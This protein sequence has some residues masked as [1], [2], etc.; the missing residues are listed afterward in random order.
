MTSEL[1]YSGCDALVQA[2]KDEGVDL[3]FGYPG[4]AVIPEFDALYREHFPVALV[5]HEQGAT[6]AAE[7]YAKSTGKTG[8]VM[9]TSGPGATNA[10]TGVA[11]AMRDSVPMVVF[12]GQV[13]TK[14]LGKEAFQEADAMA[15]MKPVT[16]QTFQVRQ[17]TEVATVVHQAFALAKSG[18]PGPVLVDLPKDV[19]TGRIATLPSHQ[20]SPATA[21]TQV[22]VARVKE[23]AAEL[24][25]AK[26]PLVVVGG[27]AVI[28]EAAH[29][30]N[31]LVHKYQLPVV[32][33][34]LGL[35]VV[36]NNDSLCFGMAG[37][38]GSFVANT[39][40]EKCDFVLGIGSR[41]EDR[42]ATDAARF[43][44]QAKV[45]Q[46]DVNPHEPGRN[47]QVDFALVGDAKAVVTQLLQ[48]LTTVA[49]HSAWNEQL[50]A[51]Q[52]ARPL[53]YQQEPDY[54][55]PEQVVQAVGKATNGRAYVVTDVGQ[56]QMWAA[57]FYPFTF[58]R[59]LITS[60][61]F[62]TMGFGLPAAVGTQFAHRDEPVVL[63]TGD[64]SLQMTVQELDVVTQ[65]R[66]NLKIVL[67]NNRRLGM[68]RQWQDLFFE[69]R[70]AS[71]ILEHQ[72][73]FQQLTQAYGLSNHRLEASDDW[74]DQLADFLA[75][76]GPG[77]LEVATAPDHQA[78]PMIFPGKSNGELYD[79]NY[80]TKEN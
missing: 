68:V 20:G 22:P 61:G 80:P 6:H 34:L 79:E 74:Q 57:Q 5:R 18:R 35:G 43:A 8:V 54:L 17:T 65:Y 31:T 12:S 71:T 41:F 64:G 14:F 25:H 38:H 39:A 36:P 42:F 70:R 47:V 37:M 58:P 75:T 53:T 63:F 77:L 29:E 51:W 26:R 56:H 19:M 52:N 21:P 7:G 33:T 27:G 73:N 4:G 28:A 69:H 49:E 40:L 32:T 15:L 59:Q 3:L 60:G 16:K 11:D 23:V 55:A 30:V 1:P 67:F 66:L 50:A 24:A 78:M 44:P 2:L 48:Q 72:P 46:I 10:I 9:V 13:G 62:G 45:A 76:P